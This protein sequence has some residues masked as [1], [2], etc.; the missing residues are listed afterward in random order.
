[1]RILDVSPRVCFPPERGSSVRTYNLLRHLALRHQIRQF[2]Q[3]RWNGLGARGATQEVQV[4]PSYLEWRYADP[5]ASLLCEVSERAWVRAPVLSGAALRLRRPSL[6]L[7]FLRW[8]D[9]VIV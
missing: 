9:V 3:A 1:M 6:L 5:A 4:S 8:A 2:S 7:E